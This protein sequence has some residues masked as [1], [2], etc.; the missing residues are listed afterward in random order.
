MIGVGNE[1]RSP[2]AFWSFLASLAVCLIAGC[3]EGAKGG[4]PAL[5][6]CG[7]N[8]AG[9]W[10][11]SDVC[12]FQPVRPAQPTSTNDFANMTPPLAPTL[13]PPQPN[14]VLQ[15]QS[16][17]GD[18]CSSLV[19]TPTGSV[20]NAVLWHDAPKLVEGTLTFIDNSYVT[21]LKFSTEGF[22]P[23]RNMT[24]FAPRCLMANGGNPTCE[25]LA[26]GLTS[27]YVPLKLSVPATYQNITCALSTVDGGCDCSYIYVVQVDD[28]GNYLVRDD[29]T[30][31]QDSH[32]FTFNAAEA[33]SQ[34]P[35]RSFETTMCATPGVSLQLS[36]PNGG[37]LAG[38]QGLRTMTLVPKPM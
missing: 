12:Q 27:F 3:G 32:V 26:T 25:Q 19:V 28:A 16:T 35:S 6:S 18:W 7:G 37:S 13:A 23:A 34:S 10:T 31:L 4:C 20:M 8:P 36:G 2:A 21:R 5:E 14:P 30:L 15:Q 33:F 24:H 22:P 11:V 38:L 29:G 1:S 9:T 17:S